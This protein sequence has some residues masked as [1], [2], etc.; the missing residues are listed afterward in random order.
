MNSL[1]RNMNLKAFDP[2]RADFVCKHEVDVNPP[3]TPE[4]EALFR[5]GLVATSYDL[6]PAK[7]DYA[8]A[9]ELWRQASE[10]GHWMAALNLADLYVEGSGVPRDSEQA[11]LIVEG[12]MQRGV[13][14]AF[15]KMGTYH[16]RGIG[17]R[18]ESSRAYA[19]WQLAADMGSAAAQAHLGSKLDANYD[20]PDQGFWGN[21]DVALKMLECG[22]AQGSGDAAFALGITLNV[23]DKSLGEDYSRALK[24]LHDG[25]KFGSAQSA[26]YLSASFDDIEPLTGNAIDTVRAERYNEL[27]EALL[28]NP[29]LRLPNLDKVLPLPPARLPMWDGKRETLVNAAKGIIVVAVAP[30]TPGSER[31]GRAHIPPG[32]VMA[33][34]AYPTEPAEAL[35][36]VSCGGYWRPRLHEVYR[37]YERDWENAQ[38]PQHYSQGEVFEAVDRSSMG[39]YARAGARTVWQFVGDAVP[40]RIPVHPRIVQGIARGTRMPEPRLRCLGALPCPRT[41]VWDGQVRADHPLAALYNRWDRCA[42]VA[43]GQ[44]FPDPRDQ[45]IGIEPHEV[46]WLWLDNANQIG[47]TGDAD[48]TLTDLHDAQGRPTA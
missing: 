9:A 40:V 33:R 35:S 39:V 15:D 6:W 14:A 46:R 10:L 28:L 3:V 12:L 21:R 47:P 37:E 2:H 34:P 20:N 38:V 1:P 17:V 19:F 11:V 48:V 5:Q 22:I 18:G 25:V 30:P 8:K 31:T 45:H 4:A 7:R 13:P 42:Y 32:H 44:S 23:D 27:G 26:D 29:D 41:G 43:K 16:Q 36:V 24:A